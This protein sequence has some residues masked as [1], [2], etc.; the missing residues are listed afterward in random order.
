[1]LPV[2][3]EPP[4]P[5]FPVVPLTSVMYY[6]GI[7][8]ETDYELYAKFNSV[9]NLT[10]Y[11]GDLFAA[12]SAVYQRDI[13]VTLKVNYLSIWTTPA[14]P[15]NAAGS[16]SAALSEFLTYWNA[17]RT[18]VPRSTA[19]MLS[20]KNLG[21]GVAYLSA[22]C[23][24]VGYG[25]S[26]SL[27]GVSPPNITT[28][29]W[30]FFV[31]THEIGHN[32]S[33]PHTHCYV[34]PVDKCWSGEGGCYSGPTSIPPEKGTIMSYCHQLGGYGA[35][36]MFLGVPAESSNAVLT[37][38]RTY[39]E[40]RP[41]CFGTVTGPNVT[42]IS[43][44]TG[45]TAGGTAVTISGTGFAGGATVKIGGSSATSVVV[46]NATTITA[47]TPAHAGGA[48]DVTVTNPGNQGY[49]LVGGYTYTCTS[50]TPT[51]SNTG[52]YCTGSTISL[53][54]PTVSGATYAWTGPNG[55]TSSIRNPTIPNATTA[56]AGT[57]SVTVTAGGCSTS[58]PGTTTVVVNPVPATPSA[59]NTGPYC[60]GATISLSTPTVSGATF[61]WTGPSGFTSAL[62]NPTIPNATTVNSG[63][64]SVT[65]TVAGCPSSPGT[66]SVTVNPRPSP[67][68]TAPASA[69]PGTTGLTASVV[70]HAGSS[71]LWGITNGTITAGGTTNQITFTAG[72]SGVTG[73][74][75]VETT[76]ATGCASPP[77]AANVYINIEP[78]GLV[79]D[80][81]AS[82][83][84]IS[85]VNSVLEPG[86]TVLVNPSW[87]NITA[88]PFAL[89]GTASAFTGPAGATYSLLDS[90]A[91]YGTIAPGATAEGLSYRLSV[92]N[93]ATRPA[94]HWD[95]TFLE[96]LSNGV[97][98][99]WTLHVGNS[100]PDVPVSDGAYRFVETLLHN[101]I[102]AGCGGGN[103]CPTSNVTRWQMAVFL[104][105]SLLGPGVPVPVS[106]TVPSVGSYSCTSGGNSLFGDVAPTNVTCPSIHYIY[107]Q[108]ITAGCGAATTARRQRLPLA[109]GRLSRHGHGGS[110]RHRPHERNRSFRL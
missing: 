84:T 26:S 34:P 66:T 73:L 39:V 12:A 4:A 37:K 22:L 90:S 31:V 82:G 76:I 110:Q 88:A 50:S 47:V 29:Y 40:G 70:L 53:S 11:V 109:D 94:T 59:S 2:P 98:K 5:T 79:E 74:S 49:T 101:G 33:S 43:P 80:A 10:N 104:A 107:A 46:V 27:S 36:K 14:D 68:I 92:S 77:A 48:A 75:V 67:Y 85:N 23:S 38:I 32:F 58:A 25:F 54:T 18:A 72:P 35:I 24:S 108:G 21:G 55:F 61:S 6:A 96:T 45:L 91:G 3:Q 19:H 103:F 102:T 41:S 16:T 65:V 99:T 8:I 83:R 69:L 95:A 63:I 9:Q 105:T 20:G 86:E 106:G 56:N 57:Y 64:Y 71:Y 13:L 44:P 100:F 17:N 52:P 87:K 81:H 78:A 30:D 62:Q 93:P 60:T 7:A 28:T 1:M 51:A 42:G 97:A 15:W 89:T